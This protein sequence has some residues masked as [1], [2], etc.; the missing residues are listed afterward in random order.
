MTTL[1]Q[2]HYVATESDI[3]DLGSRLMDG[4]EL[5]DGSRLS[6]LRAVTAT[7]QHDLNIKARSAKGKPSKLDDAEI[8]RQL[9]GINVVHDKFYAV[10]V[11][12]IDARVPK[13]RDHADE[14]NRLTN[15]ARTAIYALR[16]WVKAGRDLGRVL[17]ESVT[18]KTL[19]IEGGPKR[20]RRV[21]AEVLRKR[22]EK[23]ASAFMAQVLALAEADKAEAVA[24]LELLVGQL[25]HQL[26]ELTGGKP[27]N[28][29]RQAAEQ[30]RPFREKGSSV[31]FM[32]TQTQVIRQQANPS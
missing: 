3:A 1:E 5:T 24:E 30:H 4:I 19:V 8:A 17:P 20:A 29:L 12:T 25:T 27:T 32:P 31:V 21:S 6:Y 14:V 15:F 13:G 9:A 28:D 2:R 26:I 7:A 16:Q 10:L 22:V 18:K 23:H 11:R